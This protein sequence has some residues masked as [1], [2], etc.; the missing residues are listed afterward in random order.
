MVRTEGG[1]A[2]AERIEAAFAEIR[3]FLQSDGS[4]IELLEV[5]GNSARVRL[6][7]RYLGSPSATMT[8]QYG[9][10]RILKG[11]IPEFGELIVELL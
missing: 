8:L 5:V 4:D 10:E 1:N 3:P 6:V 7:G 9:V 11:R 2:L